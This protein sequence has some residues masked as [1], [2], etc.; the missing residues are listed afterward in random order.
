MLMFFVFFL[1]QQ[2]KVHLFSNHNY[3]QYSQHSCFHLLQFVTLKGLLADVITANSTSSLMAKTKQ[4]KKKLSLA[5][6]HYITMEI[7]QLHH[8]YLPVFCLFIYYFSAEK[9]HAHGCKFGKIK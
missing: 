3:N 2:Q 9:V 8:T 6:L 1:L 7:L 5:V 4:T